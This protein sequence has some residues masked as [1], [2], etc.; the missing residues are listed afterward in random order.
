MVFRKIKD[1]AEASFE[2]SLDTDKS[3]VIKEGS[4][5][6][7][8]SAPHCVEQLRNGKTKFAER[9]T[10]VLAEMLHEL[11][12][13]PIILKTRPEDGDAN[14]DAVCGYKTEL[15]EYVKNN[16][17]KFIIDLHQ[18]SPERKVMVNLGTG[19][20]KNVSD[21]TL[22]NIFVSSFTKEKTG[23]LQID[24]PFAGAFANTV[25]SYI[26]RNCGIP[27]MQ[28]ELNTRL[29]SEEYAEYNFEGVCKSLER[30]IRHLEK[31][32]GGSK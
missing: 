1:M 4:G 5:C 31:K 6:V 21:K 12:G 8:I 16:G 11:T 10:G 28:I 29:L 20:C 27:C 26:H 30:C 23:M 24:E 3:F 2:K 22:L 25:S 17:I 14:Y 18:L 19:N 32:L 9:Q 13:C 15:S 7:M